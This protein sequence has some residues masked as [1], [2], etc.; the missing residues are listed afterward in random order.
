[1]IAAQM[2]YVSQ[3]IDVLGSNVDNNVRHQLLGLWHIN[4]LGQGR[5]QL[6]CLCS[7]LISRS[8]WGKRA[9]QRV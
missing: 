8:R 5:G 6:L 4:A 7:S 1:M 2:P 9:A 3:H